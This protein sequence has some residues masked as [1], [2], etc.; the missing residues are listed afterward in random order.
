M[1]EKKRRRPR[2]R[3]S[4]E[5]HESRELIEFDLSIGKSLRETARNISNVNY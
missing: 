3:S 2:A 4:I 5:V 1:T